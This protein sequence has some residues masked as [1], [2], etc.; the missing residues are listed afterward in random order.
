VRNARNNQRCAA[1]SSDAYSPRNLFKDIAAREHQLNDAPRLRQMLRDY[2]RCFGTPRSD[3]MHAQRM[4]CA[5][6]K[7]IRATQQSGCARCATVVKMHTRQRCAQGATL[8]QMA[9]AA[10]MRDAPQSKMR[11]HVNQR[12]ADALRSN[13]EIA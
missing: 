7:C 13:Q 10:E 2:Q 6:S 1:L 8:D 9:Y 4:R 3:R 12:C 11:A 5:L